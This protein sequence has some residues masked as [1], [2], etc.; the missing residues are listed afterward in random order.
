MQ[1]CLIA[2]H[3]T[4]FFERIKRMRIRKSQ[5]FTQVDQEHMVVATTTPV[6]PSHISMPIE[7]GLTLP[8]S[9]LQANCLDEEQPPGLPSPVVIHFVGKPGRKRYMPW[10]IWKCYDG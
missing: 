5:A 8:D 4:C 7:K 6:V 10:S 2:D 3:L 9:F 1:P